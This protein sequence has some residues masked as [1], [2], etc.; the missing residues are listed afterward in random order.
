MQNVRALVT[1]FEQLLNQP[2]E[3]K[4]PFGDGDVL[5]GVVVGRSGTFLLVDV[6]YKSE[7]RVP[8]EEFPD[9]PPSIGTLI[10]VFVDGVDDSI[11]H[12]S[13]SKE[14]ADRM[15]IWDEIEKIA[16]ADEII[17]GLVVGKVKGGLSVDIGIKA[18]LPGSQ[19][20]LRPI[21]DLSDMVG[22]TYDFKILKHNRMRN[23]IVL[24]RRQLLEEER[25]AKRNETLGQ[26]DEGATITGVVK[27]IT[28]YGAFLDLG[29]VDGLLHITD[30]SWGR[31]THPN[32]V[33]NV[34][35][36]IEVVV[37]AFDKDKERVSLGLKQIVPDPWNGISEKFPVGSRHTGKVVSIADYGAFVELAM[38]IEGLVHVSELSWTEKNV[39]PSRIVSIDEEVTVAIQNIDLDNRR[40]SLSIKETQSNP[41]EQVSADYQPGTVIEGEVQSV[42]DFGIFVGIQDGIDG[43]VHISDMSWTR[44]VQHPR[45]LYKKGDTVRAVVLSVDVEGERFSLG[46]RQLEPNPWENLL[47][48]S[49]PGTNITGKISQKTDF[50][51]FI[52]I[53]EGIEGLLHISE[54]EDKNMDAYNIG[55]SIEVRIQSIDAIEHKV[56]LT[57]QSAEAFQMKQEAKPMSALERQI[58]ENVLKQKA[59]EDEEK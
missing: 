20:D 38:G 4:A 55:D 22:N 40:I 37:L 12:L 45:E 48:S 8:L 10:S 26:I 25:S 14:K 58:K 23:N 52:E 11:G 35:D 39:H 42:T 50:G 16:E 34:G 31:I 47:E 43:L 33:V 3:E 5:D 56:S 44:R 30:M 29:G 54:V 17:K 51:L 18:F 59:A 9:A 32:E 49:P 6:G 21:K 41:W 15:K 19:V 7:G 53:Q 1:E 46:I 36:D 27:N 13:L 28:D 57:M 24:S 2:Q